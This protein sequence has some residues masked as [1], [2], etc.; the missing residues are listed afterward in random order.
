MQSYAQWLNLVQLSSVPVRPKP[1]I[2]S[3]QDWTFNPAVQLRRAGV[4]C[5]NRQFAGT[6]PADG[7]N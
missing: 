3:I 7:T 5:R 2:A 6:I 1:A 4:V